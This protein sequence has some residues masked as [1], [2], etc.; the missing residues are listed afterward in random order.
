MQLLALE[1]S[2]LQY[3]EQ[4]TL[5]LLVAHSVALCYNNM[6]QTETL[7]ERGL[8]HYPQGR[9]C[10]GRYSREL[11]ACLARAALAVR[12]SKG[13]HPEV[14][15]SVEICWLKDYGKIFLA[16]LADFSAFW[17]GEPPTLGHFHSTF[18]AHGQQNGFPHHQ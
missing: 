17:L 4:D 6:R 3:Q 18:R 12:P 13:L 2:S 11:M 15:S 5:L 1:F 14:H 7:G 8:S 10:L 16:S 9:I